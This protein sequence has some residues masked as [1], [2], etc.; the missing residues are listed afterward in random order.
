MMNTIKINDWINSKLGTFLD[1]DGWYGNQCVDFYNF[2]LKDCLGIQ[3]PINATGGV[4]NSAVDIFRNFSNDSVLGKLGVRAIL[5]TPE[6]LPK[7]GDIIIYNTTKTNPHGH[8]EIFLEGDLKKFTAVGQNTGRGTGRDP[9]DVIKKLNRNY[10]NVLG[11]LNTSILIKD[12][13]MSEYEIKLQELQNHEIWSNPALNDTIKQAFL[14]ADAGYLAHELYWRYND[15]LTLKEEKH[16]LELN[17]EAWIL[18][19]RELTKKI[20]D[21][22]IKSNNLQKM[23]EPSQSSAPVEATKSQTFFQSKKATALLLSLA[24]GLITSFVANEEIRNTL[25]ELITTVSTVYIGGQS[26]VDMQKK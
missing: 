7:F 17:L 5:N 22:D 8:V 19:N 12:E 24:S 14:R 11:I 23:E 21:L 13:I 10:D 15:I 3:N 26:L 16:A 2:Y 9:S 18:D 1:F 6:L 25:L 4:V 20:K